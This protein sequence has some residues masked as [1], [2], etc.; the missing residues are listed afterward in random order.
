MSKDTIQRTILTEPQDWDNSS[1]NMTRP[2]ELPERPEFSDFNAEAER[3]ADLNAGQQKAYSEASRDYEGRRKEYL[4][5]T[6]LVTAARTT[7]TETISKAKLTSLH[8]DETLREWFVKLEASTAPTRGYMMERIRAQ[9]TIHLRA[10]PT[11]NISTWLARWEEIMGEAE[12]YFL[13][14]AVTGQWLR[15]IA[16]LI[17]PLSD[18]FSAI[19]IRGSK[20]LD[21]EAAAIQFKIYQAHRPGLHR[22]PPKRQKQYLEERWTYQEAARQIREIVELNPITA[23]GTVKRGA[24]FQAS[25]KED[26]TPRKKRK[27][28]SD[29]DRCPALRVAGKS[30]RNCGQAISIDLKGYARK[31]RK[32]SRIVPTYGRRLKISGQA[33]KIGN[34][35]QRP[36]FEEGWLERPIRLS[37]TQPGHRW[38]RFRSFRKAQKD[39]LITGNQNL[40]SFQALRDEGIYWDTFSEPTRLV[41]RNQTIGILQRR[42]QQFVLEPSISTQSSKQQNLEGPGP[43]TLARPAKET[44]TSGTPASLGLRNG[45]RIKGQRLWSANSVLREGQKQISRRP[46]DR[47]R[48]R[49]CHEIWI[50][51]TDLSADHEDFVRVMFITDAFTG[52]VFPYFMRTYQEKHNWAVLRDFVHWMKD[53]YGFEVKIVRSDGELFTK[54]ITA[55]LRKKGISAERSASNT[56]SQNGGAERSGGLSIERGRVMRIASRLPHNLWK[57]IRAEVQINAGSD[58]PEPDAKPGAEEELEWKSPIELFTGKNAQLSHLRA[59][60][61]RAYAM[62]ANAQLKRDKLRKLDPRAH[63]GYLVGYNSTNIFRIWI[64]YLKRVVSTRDVVFDEHTFFDG[65]LEQQSLLSGIEEL[66]QKIEIPEDQRGNQEALD[67]ETDEETDIEDLDAESTAGSTIVVMTQEEEDR[68]EE[69]ERK[70]TRRLELSKKLAFLRLPQQRIQK[71]NQRQSFQSIFLSLPLRGWGEKPHSV[72]GWKNLT[73][74]QILQ[75]L[76]FRP[77]SAKPRKRQEDP[78]FDRLD[79]FS[80]FNPTPIQDGCRG[81]FTA[82]RLFRPQ[83]KPTKVHKRDL[84]DPPETQKQLENHPYREE[85]AQAQQDHLASHEEMGSFEEISWKRVAGHQVLGCKWVFI[86]KTDKHGLL[87]KCK[88]RLVVCGNQ[89]KRGDLPTRST[90][91]AGMSFRTLMAIAAE[92][93]LELDQ[94]DAVNAFV[95]CPLEE[96]EIV[97]MR[98]PPGFQKPG[99]VLRLR[100]ALYAPHRLLEELGFKK[101]PQEPC[102]MMKGAVTVF[103]YVDDMIWAYRKEDEGLAKEAIQRLEERYKMSFLGEPK[104]FLGIH[105][106]RDRPH[107]TIWLTQDSY[108]DKIAHKYVPESL[109]PSKLPDTPMPSKPKEIHQYLQKVGSVLFSAISTRPDIAFANPD[110]SHQRAVDRVILYLYGTHNSL[111]RKSSQG[112]VMTLFGGT[113]AWKA[114]KQATAE[115][116]ALSEASKEAIFLSRLLTSLRIQIP[117][118]LLVE[119]DNSQT[120][121]LLEEGSAK[122]STRLRHVDIHQ[123]W[124]RQECQEGR[125]RVRWVPTAHMRADG[126]TKALPKQKLF[127]FQRMIGL[128]DLTERLRLE[129]RLE[130]LRDQIKDHRKPMPP[131]R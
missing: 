108:I 58:A 37:S 59:Y 8:D 110:E 80:D 93:D 30:S 16:S 131:G 121:R 17:K 31:P 4:Y 43:K 74:R 6:R 99:K 126:L 42:Y 82:G 20:R 12:Q 72:R 60:G 36:G 76:F 96:E 45:V 78:F 100:K 63:I 24:G 84:P 46:P 83:K 69:Q 11:K 26:S 92:Y 21:E 51:W 116:L 73:F 130:D 86:Y 87:Q 22:E 106:L 34:S 33:R 10:F 3:F 107:R 104:W 71:T 5:E 41:R 38:H 97:F 62:T 112:Y 89:Q 94:M 1:S 111:D 48:N 105:I 27:E 44:A 64:P 39:Y 122:L 55:W 25:P 18:G 70:T 61:C 9:Y 127:E 88:A 103:F 56:Q 15:D 29:K 119:C 98:M 54:K 129:A 118:P 14:E 32:L 123:H 114:S 101:V 75:R 49:P 53:R 109:G 65:K 90:T 95:N 52:M 13:V 81:A 91:L 113:I 67:E 57:E 79:R 50:D 40:I 19:F 124:L 102:V 77:C 35:N 85:F 68:S 117:L 28:A 2:L 125:I 47:E 23:P 115:L 7:I 128:E 66:I 120:I